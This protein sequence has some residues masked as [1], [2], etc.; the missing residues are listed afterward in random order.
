MKD[1]LPIECPDCNFLISKL[2][3]FNPFNG[4]PLYYNCYCG[5]IKSSI[6]IHGRAATPETSHCIGFHMND[7]ILRFDYYN[8][9]ITRL[10]IY[11]K[12]YKLRKV[13]SLNELL[14]INL[15]FSSFDKLNEQIEILE[16]L[17]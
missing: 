8:D 17:S 15:D 16:I 4:N 12:D 6:A 7:L 14:D 9:N 10:V 3:I 1:I 2:C 13:Y 11:N 5:K